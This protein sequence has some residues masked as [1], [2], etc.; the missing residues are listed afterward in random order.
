LASFTSLFLEIDAMINL[1]CDEMID[2]IYVY[3]V[4]ISK[5]YSEL[6][7]RGAADTISNKHQFHVI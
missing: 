6:L 2:E 7:V 3:C 1:V 4:W 5:N